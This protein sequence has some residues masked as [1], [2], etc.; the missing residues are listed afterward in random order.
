MPIEDWIPYGE[1]DEE[2]DDGVEFGGELKNETE[3][4]YLIDTGQEKDVWFP[5]SYCEK[6]EPV[7]DSW[8]HIWYVPRWLAYKKG[9]I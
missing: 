5:K 9:I 6:G 8:L 3:K 2:E 4:A 1:W 7:P